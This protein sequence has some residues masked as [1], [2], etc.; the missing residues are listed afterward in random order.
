MANI[1]FVLRNAYKEGVSEEVNKRKKE[2]KRI[3]TLLNPFETAV[4]MFFS[5]NRNNRFKCKTDL[6]IQPKEWDFK[7]QHKKQSIPGSYSFNSRLDLLK[8]NVLNYYNDLMKESPEITFNQVKDKIKLFIENDQNPDF[9]DG[10]GFFDVVED[11]INRNKTKVSP[12]TIQKYKTLKKSLQEFSS[13]KKKYNNLTF[14]QIDLNFYDDYKN[15]L[16]LEVDNRRTGKKGYFND[17]VSKYFENLKNFM[18]WSLDR[19]VHNNREFQR[20]NFS[21]SRKPKQDIVTLE[22]T[23]LRDFY[24]YDF[25]E[26]KRLEQVRDL[27]C[28][29][30]FTG[31]R[32]SDIVKFNR[33]DFQGDTWTFI[34][35]KT[36][37]KTTIPFLGYIAPALDILKKYEYK[38]PEISNQKF[39]D[40]I[41][42]AGKTAELTRS[43]KIERLQGI[44]KVVI[45]KPLYEFITMHTGRRTCVSLLLNVEKMP[46]PQ[47][48]DITQHTDFK[49]LRKYINEDKDALRNNLRNTRN[50]NDYKMKVVKKAGNY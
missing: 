46:I 47:V 43:V 44:D 48:M 34:S 29:A 25:S 23:E 40:Y 17:T 4:L 37:K 21:A 19:G 50:V 2:D 35:E 18:N 27:F 3:D 30:T 5:Y 12:R 45:E 20:R 15:Y 10:T 32:W 24:N 38:L 33:N 22:F 16:L 11:Y 28:F 39:N 7:K 1:N 41:K 49:T 13:S 14:S 36:G 31:Q 6:K 26:N 8:D 9:E 42:E